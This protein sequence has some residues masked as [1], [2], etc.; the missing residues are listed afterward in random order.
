MELPIYLF[1]GF[2]EGG[3][4]SMIQ[5]SLED[6]NFNSG[7]KTLLLVCEEGVEEFDPDRFW[8]KNVYFEQLDNEKQLNEDKLTALAK[9]HPYDRMVVELNGMWQIRQ[10]YEAMPE[11]AYINEQVFVADAGTFENYNANMRSLV[12]D[13]LSGAQMVVFNRCT[14]ATD[15]MR[16]HKIVRGTTRQ[17]QIYYEYTDGHVMPDEI[18]DPLPFDVNAPVITIEDKDYALWYRD[19]NEKLKDYEGKTVRFKGVAAV[20]ARMPKD[21]FV[22][23]RHVMNCCAADIQYFGLVAVGEGLPK[24]E[25]YAWFTV[26]AKIMTERHKLYRGRG[27]VLHV[28]SITPA[29]APEEKVATF[30]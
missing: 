21:T 17:A 30:Y 6:K 14:E 23:G 8:G 26:E 20:D 4:T 27:P 22:I 3:K 15:T 24:V 5:S 19:L 18:E 16:L 1:T 2:L 12:V 10:F 7:E 29:I 25:N 11:G 13:K 9:K 28:T